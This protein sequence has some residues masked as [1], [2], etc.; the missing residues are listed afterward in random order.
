MTERNVH[1]GQ[2][3]RSAARCLKPDGVFCSFSPCVE[4]VQR[5]CGALSQAG[6]HSVRTMECLLR[7]YDVRSQTLIRDVTSHPGSDPA[8]SGQL[9]ICRLGQRCS[10]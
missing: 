6:F 2:V 8:P 5:T 10:V 1:T 4:Q 3:V 9:P 7:L